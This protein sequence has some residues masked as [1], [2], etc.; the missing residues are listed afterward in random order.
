VGSL[1][2][3]EV[4]TAESRK[5]EMEHRDAL[6]TAELAITDVEEA[7]APPPCKWISYI[8]TKFNLAIFKIDMDSLDHVNSNSPLPDILHDQR[9]SGQ[10]KAEATAPR[11]YLDW[12]AAGRRQRTGRF[13]APLSV[14][15]PAEAF[16]KGPGS[17]YI[18]R[19]WIS[20]LPTNPPCL[21]LI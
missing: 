4:G 6:G 21:R 12:E 10:N 8:S 14:I 2:V 9:P 19:M 17:R 15:I 20:Y 7:I 3:Q 5:N 11:T 1:V 18:H 13:H 16:E